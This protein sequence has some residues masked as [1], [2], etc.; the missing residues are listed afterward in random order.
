MRDQ[1]VKTIQQVKR[2]VIINNVS[3]LL[4]FTEK[5][6]KLYELR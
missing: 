1:L 3:L 5:R 4:L 2:S 6:V